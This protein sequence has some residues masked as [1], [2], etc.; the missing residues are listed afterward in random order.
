MKLPTE[1]LVDCLRCLDRPNLD[2]VQ[3]STKRLRN[4]V[5]KLRDVCL[6]SLQTAVLGAA[7]E[8]REPLPGSYAIHA[9]PEHRELGNETL[10]TEED[11][12]ECFANLIASSC[13]EHIL[14]NWVMRLTDRVLQQLQP[15][16]PSVRV[17]HLLIRADLAPASPGVF[18]ETLTAFGSIDIL[19][20]AAAKNL[21]PGHI[22]DALVKYAADKGTRQVYLPEVGEFECDVTD[23]SIL[24]FLKAPGRGCE[25]RRLVVWR[26]RLSPQFL[27]RLVEFYEGK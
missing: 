15:V 21:Q 20:F 11:A 24:N 5:A 8:G 6:R 23:E 17:G 26:P 16:L 27:E 19:R 9:R 4:A 1:T 18:V 22:S 10:W 14:I 3:I 25:A 12:G 7:Y 2:A 13:I